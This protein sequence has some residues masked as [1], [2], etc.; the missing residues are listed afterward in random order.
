MK[1]LKYIWSL[2]NGLDRTVAII[3]IIAIIAL[4]F[5]LNSCNAQNSTDIPTMEYYV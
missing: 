4:C 5:T 3:S 1:T 2:W